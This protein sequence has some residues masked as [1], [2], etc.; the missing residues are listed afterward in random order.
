M[1]IAKY[2][3]PRRRLF[4]TGHVKMG[5]V[6]VGEKNSRSIHARSGPFIHISWDRKWPIPEAHRHSFARV[7]LIA[8]A[9]DSKNFSGSWFHCYLSRFFV[10]LVVVVV[11]VSLSVAPR[12][13]SLQY[14]GLLSPWIHREDSRRYLCA[15]RMDCNGSMLFIFLGRIYGGS[16]RF[17]K[18]LDRRGIV[19][20]VCLVTLMPVTIV[21][22]IFEIIL[23]SNCN[24]KNGKA[25]TMKIEKK[26]N[27]TRIGSMKR[28]NKI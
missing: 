20:A 8:R 26:R 1:V 2:F 5:R 19:E 15:G 3:H 11:S 27:E 10:T 6:Q 17:C 14:R 23:S 25:T 16:K 28:S 7:L 9:D 24:L 13:C 4:E 21:A 12:G 22:I 18:L